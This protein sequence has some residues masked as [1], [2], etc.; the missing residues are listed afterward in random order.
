MSKVA[1]AAITTNQE[2]RRSNSEPMSDGVPRLR[3]SVPQ[4]GTVEIA[5]PAWISF[6]RWLLPIRS[7]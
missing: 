5:V 1:K 3:D 7:K 2:S 6:G 4:C